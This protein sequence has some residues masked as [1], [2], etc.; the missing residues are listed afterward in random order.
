MK[1]DMLDFNVIKFFGINIRTGKV[2]RPFPVRWEFPSLG[3]VKINT[4]GAARGYP[5]LHTCGAIFCG[6]YLLVGSLHFLTFVLVAEFYGVIYA[7][8]ET[9]RIGLTSVWP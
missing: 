3:W 4:D 9:Q 8:E 7:M 2:F 1:N 6:S 5:G